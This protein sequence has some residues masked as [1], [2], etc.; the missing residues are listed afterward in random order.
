MAAEGKGKGHEE[1][2][3]VDGRRVP[4]SDR[5]VEELLWRR[6]NQ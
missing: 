2:Q 5:A 1:C 6:G 3:I 4:Y